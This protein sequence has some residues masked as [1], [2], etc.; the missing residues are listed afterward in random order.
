MAR[1]ENP[2][3]IREAELGN[4][5]I[6]SAHCIRTP[7]TL[8]RLSTDSGNVIRARSRSPHCLNSTGAPEK[9]PESLTHPTNRRKLGDAH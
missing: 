9:R 6:G 1:T 3:N 8:L 7:A 2:I 5:A 4:L